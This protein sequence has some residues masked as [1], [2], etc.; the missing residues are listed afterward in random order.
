MDWKEEQEKIKLE[1]A[2]LDTIDLLPYIKK[3][4]DILDIM[5][6]IEE[7]YEDC[8]Y[9]MTQDD[10]I[11]YLLGRYPNFKYYEYTEYRVAHI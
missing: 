10:F 2:F 11:E 3:N 9:C 1:K 7:D 5:D 6:E 4:K 8:M